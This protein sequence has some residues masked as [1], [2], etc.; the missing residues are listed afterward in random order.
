MLSR[1]LRELY[2]LVHIANRT[3]CFKSPIY[4]AQHSIEFCLLLC[5]LVSTQ[6]SFVHYSCVCYETSIKIFKVILYSFLSSVDFHLSVHAIRSMIH[7]E[8][9]FMI[10]FGLLFLRYNCS[11][12]C[13]LFGSSKMLLKSYS[14]LMVRL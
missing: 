12:A 1:D 4:E 6:L 3:Q 13:F 9:D 7:C 10:C 5:T 11:A 8:M 14:I 2:T